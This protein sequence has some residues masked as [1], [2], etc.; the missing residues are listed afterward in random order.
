VPL[1]V[2]PFL[3]TY[4][5]SGDNAAIYSSLILPA[6]AAKVERVKP[7]GQGAKRHGPL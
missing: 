3:S 6:G 5:K 7:V 1:T 2:F 4:A